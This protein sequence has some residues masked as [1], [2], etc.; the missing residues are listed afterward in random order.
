MWT[1][2]L[3]EL[4]QCR[5]TS[6]AVLLHITNPHQ[7]QLQFEAVTIS[8]IISFIR[9]PRRNRL[10]ILH[11]PPRPTRSPRK[12]R[13][14]QRRKHRLPNSRVSPIDLHRNKS[15]PQSAWNSSHPYSFSATTTKKK[16][17][18]QDTQ[19]HMRSLISGEKRLN[20]SGERMERA[21]ALV[22]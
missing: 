5:N 1:N 10:N 17:Y 14:K 2:S 8:P 21:A 22:N 7:P 12:M 3:I 6:S 20:C 13:T 11:P 9:R 15:L 16:K 18:N 4:E 19:L